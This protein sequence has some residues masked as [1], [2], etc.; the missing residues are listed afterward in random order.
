METV[1]KGT[2][3]T[4]I[5]SV[6]INYMYANTTKTGLCHICVT[7]RRLGGANWGANS[8]L[9]GHCVSTLRLTK[10]VGNLAQAKTMVAHRT[11]L[12][13]KNSVMILSPFITT[14]VTV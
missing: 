13:F 8:P 2:F 4:P 7:G 1:F 5:P 9:R 11:L 3:P 12:I 6:L 14:T 10:V